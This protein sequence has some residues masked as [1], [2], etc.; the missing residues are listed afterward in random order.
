MKNVLRIYIPFL[1]YLATNSFIRI[2]LSKRESALL[3]HL[4]VLLP[5]LRPTAEDVSTFGQ[6]RKFPPHARKTSGT[7]GKGVLRTAISNDILNLKRRGNKI[8]E[9]KDYK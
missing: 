1:L 9:N 8:V 2:L 6:H 3:R 5:G 7:E 4:W